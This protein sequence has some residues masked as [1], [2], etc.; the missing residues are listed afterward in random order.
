MRDEQRSHDGFSSYETWAQ[1]VLLTYHEESLGYWLA[2]AEAVRRA[3][4]GRGGDDPAEEA[5]RRLLAGRLRRA[6][7]VEDGAG[8]H[9]VR[10]EEIAREL[11]DEP[12]PVRRARFP[13]GELLITPGAFAALTPLDASVALLLHSR[14]IWGELD[15]EDCEENERALRQGGRLRSAYDAADGRRFHVVTE[16]DRSA[17]A[18]L[19]PAECR[20]A[21]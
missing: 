5:C 2:E 19:L 17:T 16:A 3:V 13:V 14:G 9:P 20:A 6:H 11:L 7:G 15:E 21:R 4:R 18:V 8:A 1:C 10:W 12:L